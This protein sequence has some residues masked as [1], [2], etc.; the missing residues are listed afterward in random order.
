MHLTCIRCIRCISCIRFWLCEFVVC[1]DLRCCISTAF[2]LLSQAP[3]GLNMHLTCI[4]CIRCITCIRFWFCEFVV[5][6]DLR[7]GIST[8]FALLSQAPQDSAGT[9][10]VSS[11]SISC[12][13]GIADERE[14]ERAK[15]C[16]PNPS[17]KLKKQTKQNKLTICVHLRHN[18]EVMVYQATHATMCYRAA[19]RQKTAK[20]MHYVTLSHRMSI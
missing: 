12:R 2:A 15:T 7:C 4:R 5:C 9:W 13:F 19:D 8:A 11:L 10:C 3:T 17:D 18:A 14:R 6:A 20:H 1:A 16:K